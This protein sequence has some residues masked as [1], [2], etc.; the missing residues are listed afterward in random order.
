MD[1]RCFVASA[2]HFF[3]RGQILRLAGLEDD[4]TFEVF[5][6]MAFEPMDVEDVFRLVPCGTITVKRAGGRRL[7]QGFLL[8]NML[9]GRLMWDPNPELPAPPE[10]ERSLLIHGHG[11]GVVHPRAGAVQPTPSEVAALCGSRADAIRLTDARITVDNVLSQGY[12]CQHL[13]GVSFT[14]DNL[15]AEGQDHSFVAFIDC[16]PL[17]Q[18]WS[19]ETTPDGRVSYEE[20]TNWLD[21]FAPP[22]W[23]PQ[24][25]GA[26]IEAGF[27]I[28]PHGAVLTA[29]YVPLSSSDTRDAQGDDDAAGEDD[30]E[31]D[32][33]SSS[34]SDGQIDPDAVRDVSGP[35]GSGS[36]GFSPP[37]PP[38][39]RGSPGHRSRSRSRGGHRR[40]TT[41]SPGRACKVALGFTLSASL[42]DA[43]ALCPPRR[44][45]NWCGVDIWQLHL[46]CPLSPAL[47]LIALCLLLVMIVVA[48][49]LHS[50]NGQPPTSGGATRACKT[51]CEPQGQNRADQG[52]IDALRSLA[53]VL[54]GS[55]P[56]RLP[57]PDPDLPP[58]DPEDGEDPDDLPLAPPSI[59][60]VQGL[61]LKHDFVP[62]VLPIELR[63]PAVAEEVLGPL[64]HE[65][66][67]G[68]RDAFPLLLAVLPQPYEGHLVCLGVPAWDYGVCVCIDTCAIYGRLFAAYAP[69]YATRR[70]LL[71]LTD[72]PDDSEVVVWVGT[73]ESPLLDHDN[74]HMSPGVLIRFLPAD[75]MHRV[76]PT[77][78]ETLLSP[79][80]WLQRADVP[81]PN[82]A[83]AY[84]LLFAGR[85]RLYVA[86]FSRPTNYRSDIASVTGAR[87]TSMQL[88]SAQPRP[89]DVSLCG[90]PCRTVIAVE[91]PPPEP[92]PHSRH[93]VLLDCRRLIEGW[94]VAYARDGWLDALGILQDLA[95][96]CPRG[97]KVRFEQEARDDGFLRATPGCV[98]VLMLAPHSP[99]NDATGRPPLGQDV[100]GG[101]PVPTAEGEHGH[102]GDDSDPNDDQDPAPHDDGDDDGPE[103]PGAPGHAT[104]H[105][106]VFTPDYTPEYLSIPVHLPVPLPRVLVLIA[107]ARDPNR[108]RIFPRLLPVRMQPALPQACVL[109]LPDWDFVGV[110]VLIACDLLQF[111]A[112]AIMVPSYLIRADVL[113]LAGLPADARV[114]VF[115]S[116]IPWAYQGE[117]RLYVAAGDLIRICAIEHP[118]VPPLEFTRLFDS[119]DGW[120]DEPAFMGPYT[121]C[122][123]LLSDQRPQRFPVIRDAEQHLAAAVAAHLGV[124]EADLTVAHASGPVLDHA[125][126]G[127]PSMQIMLAVQLELAGDVP[128]V[129]DQRP[130]MLG[131]QWNFAREG[132]IDVQALCQRHQPWCP[133]GHFLRVVGG[134][135][136]GDL[137]NHFRFVYPG[138]LI[139]VEFHP[140]RSSSSLP[141]SADLPPPADGDDRQRDVTDDSLSD[142]HGHSATSS[143]SRPDAGTGSTQHGYGPSGPSQRG[144][145][146]SATQRCTVAN[147]WSLG[148][149]HDAYAV[150]KPI[151][152]PVRC[153]LLL[154]GWAVLALSGDFFKSFLH[155]AWMLDVCGSNLLGP[156]VCLSLV[157][158][159]SLAY[160][161]QGSSQLPPDGHRT[162]RRLRPAAF[163]S[164]PIR[165]GL[166]ALVVLSLLCT[167]AAGRS[168]PTHGD[169]AGRCFGDLPP[170]HPRVIPTPVRSS[171]SRPRITPRSTHYAVGGSSPP[172]LM[173]P[174]RTLLEESLAAPDSEAMFC[175]ATLLETL[176]EYFG[177]TCIPSYA[178]FSR[179]APDSVRRDEPVSSPIASA[180]P[181]LCLADLVAPPMPPTSSVPATPPVF[182][183]D[184]RQC[185]LPGTPDRIADLLCPVVMKSLQGM[186]RD[187]QVP[188]VC[189]AWLRHGCVGRSPGPQEL[190]VLTSDGSFSP[191]QG[192]IGWGIT[193]SLSAST[194]HLPGQFVGCLFGDLHSFFDA[195][196]VAEVCRD[197]YTAEVA[198]L[199][200]CALLVLQLRVSCPILIR[201]DNASALDGARGSCQM[202]GDVLCKAARC[203][204]VAAMQCAGCPVQYLHVP[205]HSG[206]V[207]NEVADALAK[208]GAS[209]KQ[210]LSPLCF[211]RFSTSEDLSFLHWLPHVCFTRSRSVEVPTLHE[212]VLSWSRAP[213]VC[214]LPPDFAMRPFLR[215]FP[216]PEGQDTQPQALQC[217]RWTL[218]SFNA[219]SLQ[220]GETIKAAGQGLH[221]ATGRPSVLR[222]SLE[223]ADVQ[224][225][226]MQECRTPKGTLRCGPFTRFSSGADEK[227]C[228]GVE[229]WVHDHS[230]CPAT[231]IV[232]LHASPTILVAS[233]RFEGQPV[234]FIVAHGPHRAHAS[235]VKQDWWK[236]LTHL[237]HSYDGHGTWFLMLDANCRVGSSTSNA[238]GDCQADPEDESGQLFHKLLL[239]LDA[240]VPATFSHAMLGEG[241]T[242]RQKRSGEFDR[243]DYV[244]VPGI[245]RK[246]LC[247]AWVEPHISAGHVLVD[248]LAAMVMLEI[249]S[250]SR[251][252]SARRAKRIDVAALADP[253]NDAVVSQIIQTAP[254]PRWEIDASEHAALLVDHLYRGLSAAF[255][256]QRKRMRTGYLSEQSEALH[257][258]VA[259]LR[260]SVRSRKAAHRLAFIRCAWLAWCS[261]TESFHAFFC[262]KWL[263]Q[264]E[265]RLGLSCMLL[266]R[267]GIA[268]RRSCRGDRNAMYAALAEEVATAPPAEV[269]HAVKRVLRPRK[270][271]K[272]NLDPLPTLYKADGSQ[273]L[274]EVEVTDTWRE[275]FRVLEG[276]SDTTP[277]D[278]LEECR[279]RQNAFEGID[280]IDVA[281]MPAWLD[282]EASFRHMSGRKAAGPD[283]LPPMLCRRFSPQLTTVFWPL[284]L[285]TLCRTSEAAGMKGG[286]LHH[287]G[288]PQ[289]KAPHTCDAHRGILVQSAFSKAFHRS[290]RGLLVR[291]WSR[292]ALPLQIGGRAGCS[293]SFGSLCSR[294]ILAYARAQG[295]S[296]GLVFID[297]SAAYYA[298]IRETLFGKGMSERPVEE[299]AA[300]LN[301]GPDDLQE[302]ARLIEHEAILPQ[303]GASD[304][305]QEIAREF[306]Q[307]TW[308]ILSGDSHMVATHRGTRP[309]GTLADILF[310]ILFGHAL[311]RRKSGP[312]S[313]AIPR[314]PWNGVRTPFAPACTDATPR[315][316]IPDV[317][318]ADDLC[319]PVVC[320]AA[321]QL[322][323]TV[324]AVAADTFDTLAPHALR[325]NF[326][327]TKTAAVVA[328]AG[329]GSRQ[330][331]QEMFGVLRG[332]TPIWAECRG[333]QW[334]DLVARYRHL[335]AVITHDGSITADVKHRLAL[336][337]VAFRDGKRRLF[338]C[339][340]IPL[341]K[342]AA[343]FR[344]HVLSSLLAGVG[345]WP[346]LGICDWKLFSRG[347]FSL[348]RQL[349]GLRADGKWNYTADQLLA[350]SGLPSPQCM[351]HVERLRFLSQLVRHGPDELWALVGQF[352][353]YQDALRDAGAWLLSAVG[354][355]VCLGPIDQDWNSWSRL[356]LQS[357]GKWKG[358]LKRAEAWHGE[359]ARL[360]AL[361]DEVVRIAWQPNRLPSPS[362][363]AGLEHGCLLCGLAFATRQQWGAHAHKL[364]GYRNTATQYAKGR[365]CRACGSQYTTQTRLRSHLLS[366]ARCLQFL[367]R[368]GD[369]VSVSDVSEGHVQAP[370]LRGWGLAHL[371]AA[372][373]ETCTALRRG[374][375]SL[376]DATDQQIYDEVSRHIAPL[377]VLSHTLSTWRD[378]LPFGT[379]RDSA[380]DVLLVLSPEHLCSG[381]AG[382]RIDAT[383]DMDV[384]TP[385]L[386]PTRLRCP[387]PS[388]LVLAFGVPTSEWTSFWGFETC[389][390]QHVALD[391]LVSQF[392]QGVRCHGIFV[393]FPPPPHGSQPIRQPHPGPLRR[394]REHSAWLSTLLKVF[395]CLYRTAVLGRPACL[396]L[397]LKPGHLEPIT[398]W[399]VQS[400]LTQVGHQ[401]FS[402]AC[403]TL[404]FILH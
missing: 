252:S 267:Y 400:D 236:R 76:L 256:V 20:L 37:D 259:S 251:R 30:D 221:G 230:P 364:H 177:Q 188:Q 381:L 18:G 117:S 283:L 130:V 140:F 158:F 327:P 38:G 99:G 295:L 1:G 86:D 387:A 369:P 48:R 255:P 121:D 277:I 3:N 136:A 362:P 69:A 29:S 152:T 72:I 237:C 394:L 254:R 239:E 8:E 398:T 281:D 284:L 141:D 345:S 382:R 174:F 111:R 386:L 336:A 293:A 203:L 113:H 205:G 332:K 192:R 393:D 371:P 85:A 238:I 63:L 164:T 41:G 50:L 253:E 272:A 71:S 189:H 278:L 357:P 227:S 213:G 56:T 215:A 51:L 5:P 378:G 156:V 261:A 26:P 53:R 337:R 182:D 114:A 91:E 167:A 329:A 204:H 88:F 193:C 265:V 198:G 135:A 138:Q 286:V 315:Q 223:E 314:I 43:Y 355:T 209:G 338:A 40:H 11:S 274:S 250:I 73:D 210:A 173:G 154:A 194:D 159:G 374:L 339:K 104:L 247:Q 176:I 360:R 106:A 280:C 229:L 105:F 145:Y 266:R 263:L 318:Y 335:G 184:S 181:A 212:Q 218:A 402:P 365:V 222:A 133:P 296:A 161:C 100:V 363:L 191:A 308:F 34:S 144:P 343:L 276:G 169:V 320:D 49:W 273:C 171:H 23:Q 70:D 352:G 151:S 370:V 84:C 306:H 122:F 186:P 216:S 354:D 384:F 297:L 331:R 195:A 155:V 200:G 150:G 334:L 199:L 162:S 330:A 2:P 102:D 127:F 342:R 380:S 349:L 46:S 333:M 148:C 324:S 172:F 110:P 79:R 6:F 224:I 82:L 310:S 294:A 87:M 264:L 142:A 131:M 7:V 25:E 10:G 123:W 118:V 262:G 211:H 39:D 9:L 344:S 207:A 98:F 361:F 81:R 28:V 61:I 22:E 219:L 325:V 323:H 240:W 346:R 289:P 35:R 47:L 228:F 149:K 326:G 170:V 234:R 350:M 299:I 226:G 77:L 179:E 316:D 356:L 298:V 391:F 288:K 208:L 404:E 232:V 54:G 74:I 285:K 52:R 19:M 300:A 309:G 275:H 217:I 60:Q 233:G 12:H 168:I 368:A 292:V 57:P 244:A 348:Y 328:P 44:I 401:A 248:H 317:V 78:G 89:V 96:C 175:A 129:L 4:G 16:R 128:F 66:E 17:L 214:E 390:V 197:A 134:Y 291:H 190:L 313:G 62:E 42:A 403:F 157:L 385:L 220:D 185:L 282:L 125:H 24:I 153:M 90:V 183:L 92:Q 302:L 55:W 137:G 399:V 383:E 31:E 196:L 290:L 107:N 397:A 340:D 101:T 388:P 366:S 206:E 319:I 235:P 59:V 307:H 312:L 301:L 353:S 268:L 377:P 243:S 257:R 68:I 389:G 112:F 108:R 271:R 75:T 372:Q 249:S 245:W 132:R 13:F 163:D 109:A 64:Q 146:P 351:L 166:F 94:K 246:S 124:P 80:W 347:V 187:V 97:W 103:R 341:P 83:R 311:R 178:R 165:I 65:R 21:T 160:C 225:A 27:L 321:S 231:S 15:F 375:D 359:A 270:F 116:D 304:L 287:I 95:C 115:L 303:Q 120:H 260:H 45:T 269:H 58:P 36:I 33:T 180:L 14:E 241:G 119:I 202:R 258:V 395:C 67:P 32:D 376:T 143:S 367:E 201:A 279:S 93:P 358:V 305:M 379:L 322:R 139:T 373:P 147:M 126:A 242:L 392:S 396:R